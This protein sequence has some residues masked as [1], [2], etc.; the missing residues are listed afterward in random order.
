[1]LRK[2]LSLAGATVGLCL[3]LTSCSQDS[4]PVRTYAMGE[5]VQLGHLIYTVFET[6]WMTQ[7]GQGP[8]TRVPQQR[9]FAVRLS[10]TNAGSA[11]AVAPTLQLVDDSGQTLTEIT[12]GE[13]LTSWLGQIRQIRPA[14][15]AQGNVLFDVAPAHYKLRIAD[16][17]EQ[18]IAL[19][20]IPLSFSTETPS[21]PG[22]ENVAPRPDAAPAKKK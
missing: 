22:L 1:M 13:G 12:D 5:R 17:G 14:E 6:Q 21:L 20:D 16:E 7:L 19:V 11:D 2:F 15:S 10:I 18:N 3:L 9:F 8:T 4:K